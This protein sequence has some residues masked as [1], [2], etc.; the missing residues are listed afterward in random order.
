MGALEPGS[1]ALTPLGAML[2]RLPMDPRLAKAL[3]YGCLLQCAGPVLSTAAALS[4]GR[5]LFAAVP[6]ELRAGADAGRAAVSP[7]A[8]AAK[9]D[10]L[11]LAEAYAAWDAA[12]AGENGGGGG[13]GGGGGR[14][15]AGAG[16]R[17]AARDLASRCFLSDGA[18]EATRSARSDLARTMVEVGLLPPGYPAAASAPGA[19]SRCVA[20]SR[21]VAEARERGD[22]HP[23]ATDP[24]ALADAASHSARVVKAAL[25]AGFAPGGLLRVEHPVDKYAATLGGAVRVDAPARSLRFRDERGSRVFIHPASICFSAGRFDSGWLVATGIVHVGG[26]AS[27]RV[28]S[29]APAYGVLLFGGR[30][31]VRHGDGELVMDGWARFAAP[32]RTGVLIRELR[33][34]VDGLLAAKLA[35]P[36]VSLVGA[37]AM[38]AMHRLLE[39]DGF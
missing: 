4:H 20:V 5:P 39:T 14:G 7:A 33:A 30:L 8:H 34:A 32:A 36:G 17:A 19:A 2:A 25:C 12:R 37:P 35:D 26:K 23:L 28:V 18:M 38:G 27:T 31:D 10:H 1:E 24:V 21:E 15:S 29:A 6:P 3:V 13:G 22:A 11:A 16:G 9:S